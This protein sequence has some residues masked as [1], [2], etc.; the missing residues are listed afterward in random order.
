MNYNKIQE[1]LESCH[2][3]VLTGAPGTGKTYLARKIAAQ[4]VLGKDEIDFK[5]L[6]DDEK[7][8]IKDR[9]AFVQFHPS[10]D[11]TDFVEGLRP[12]QQGDGIKFERRDG[13]FKLFCKNA[14]SAFSE[15]YDQLVEDIREGR[16]ETIPT[17]KKETAKLSVLD[18]GNIKWYSEQEENNTSS[19]CVSKK[20]LKKL[21]S[22][23]DSIEKLNTIKS[24]DTDIKAV[25]R[26][27]D[28]T[29]YWAVL[30][31]V[32]RK[33][34]GSKPYVIIIDEINRG[35]LS[36]IFG[37]L[38]FS[39]DPGYRGEKGRVRTQYQNLVTKLDQDGNEDPFF[40]GFY[41][42]ENV[43]IIGTMND[44]DRSIESMDFAIRRRFA[45]VEVKADK[46]IDMLTK[47]GEIK[48]KAIEVM[49]ALNKAVSGI[50][51]LSSAYHI[52]A[53]YFLKL[54]DYKD[55]DN[56]FKELWDYHLKGLLTEYLRGMG[57]AKDNM[58]KLEKAYYEAAGINRQH[59]S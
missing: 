32:L 29:Y 36:K 51:G 19:N 43:Y 23:Y 9:T 20:R 41:V 6:T 48:D 52:G 53:S 2:N 15:T 28:A 24:I 7:A 21:Y 16:I 49:E 5:K 14:I 17:K 18:N 22:Q 34:Q 33:M 39:I 8:V 13:I 30:N 27:C 58:T 25:I 11:Y 55:S 54:D 56:P 4:M 12:N 45:W 3:I 37:E 35:E 26:G 59:Q 10:Y 40:E 57:D 31:Y 38:F 42:P 50:D 46:N 47:L 1:L 44:I